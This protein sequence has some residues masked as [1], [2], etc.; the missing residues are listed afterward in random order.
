MRSVALRRAARVRYTMYVHRVVA[1]I[2]ALWF[3]LGGVL[4]TRHEA[5]VAHVQDRSGHVVHAQALV[6]THDGTRSDMHARDAGHDHDRCPFA[7]SLHHAAV[8]AHLAQVSGTT[9]AGLLVEIAAAP[10]AARVYRYAPKTSPP[11]A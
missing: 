5:R 6:G 4:A 9:V 10:V 3:V 7:A 11:H 1:A 2:V 8:A